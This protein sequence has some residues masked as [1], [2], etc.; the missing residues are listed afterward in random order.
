MPDGYYF[1]LKNINDPNHAKLNNMKSHDLSCVHGD[2]FT[3][4]IWWASK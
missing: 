1:N 4:C 3:H 2:S